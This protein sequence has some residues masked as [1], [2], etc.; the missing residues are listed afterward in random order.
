M[1]CARSCFI[2]LLI[3]DFARLGCTRIREKAT[4]LYG[5][6]YGMKTKY[7]RKYAVPGVRS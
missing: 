6:G 2:S 5:M 3:I 1:C 4:G 7:R